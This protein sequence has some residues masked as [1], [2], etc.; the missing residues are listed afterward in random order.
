MGMSSIHLVVVVGFLVL[1]GWG[2]RLLL[3][4][5]KPAVGEVANTFKFRT[6]VYIVLALVVPLW[7]ITLPLFL[8]LAYKSYLA[9][10]ASAPGPAAGNGSSANV[11]AEIEAL[12]R[13][14]AS[15][16][17]TEAEFNAKKANLLGLTPSA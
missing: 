12:H 11:A 7:L 2:I 3:G 16:A 8:Y 5:T 4:T 10:D 15:G 17:L 6:V 9:G 14:V 13:L 1:I